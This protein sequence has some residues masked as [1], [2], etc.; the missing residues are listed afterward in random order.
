MTQQKTQRQMCREYLLEFLYELM[1]VP[2]QQ[3]FTKEE[4]GQVY[5]RF[6]VRKDQEMV[7]E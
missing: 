7:S 2:T 6:T 5:R 1:V 4:I 3:N